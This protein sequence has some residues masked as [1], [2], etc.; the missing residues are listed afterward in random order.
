L[1]SSRLIILDESFVLVDLASVEGRLF[2]EVEVLKGAE[3]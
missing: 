1:L 2:L 3:T